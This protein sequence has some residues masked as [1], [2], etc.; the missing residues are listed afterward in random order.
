MKWAIHFLIS[1]RICFKDHLY[2]SHLRCLLKLWVK[3]KV[4]I[5]QSSL[6]LCNPMDWSLPGS[7]VHETSQGKI[8]EWVAI[9]FSWGY[10]LPRVRTRIS[11]HLLHWEVDSLPLCQPGNPVLLRELSKMGPGDH[12]GGGFTS[13]PRWNL[14]FWPLIDLKQA[15]RT[16]TQY[17]R[18]P[19]HLS[20]P[21]PK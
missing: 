16:S 14:N 15:H 6:N 12:W 20:E 2:Q 3:V 1:L 19:R 17:S 4:L 13:Q 5:T 18:N 10:S 7:S 21:F 9:S 8:L 11:C